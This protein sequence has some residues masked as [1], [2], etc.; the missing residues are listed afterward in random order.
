VAAYRQP[1]YDPGL[2]G[3]YSLSSQYDPYTTLLQKAAAAGGVITMNQFGD[4]RVVHGVTD[5][6]IGNPYSLVNYLGGV[7][8]VQRAQKQNPTYAYSYN[9]T[10]E[11]QQAAAVKKAR[12]HAHKV[13]VGTAVGTG[14]GVVVGSLL[15][16]PGIGAGLGG[17]AGGYLAGL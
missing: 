8:A 10:E 15:G 7:Q 12:K 14:L 9:Q 6:R 13:A 17:L 5:P 4:P 2:Q 16:N 11:Q 3:G 1:V